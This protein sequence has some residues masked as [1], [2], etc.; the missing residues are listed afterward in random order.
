MTT[1]IEV[2]VTTNGQP[3]HGFKVTFH[4]WDKDALTSWLHTAKRNA[5]FYQGKL[6]DLTTPDLERDL[7]VRLREGVDLSKP[8]DVNQV[9]R[10]CQSVFPNCK[11]YLS[12]DGV[13][14]VDM[15]YIISLK[16]LPLPGTHANQK[17]QA[18]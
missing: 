11:T 16:P 13:L 8:L 12:E 1:E 2:R 10:I 9:D 4:D 7:I 14:V 3:Q 18:S 17:D 6:E 5:Q 15:K